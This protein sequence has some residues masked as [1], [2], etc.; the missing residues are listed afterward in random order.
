MADT[1]LDYFSKD[2][3]NYF[4]GGIKEIKEGNCKLLAKEIIKSLGIPSFEIVPEQPYPNGYQACVKQAALEEKNK[5]YP[6]YKE[7]V[8]IDGYKNIVLLFP[9]WMGTYPRLIAAFLKNHDLKNKNIL[10]IVSN[11]G[12]GLGH[13][14]KDLKDNT[15]ANILSGIEFKGH[16]VAKRSDEIVASIAKLMEGSAL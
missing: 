14:L 10:P 8:S 6:T 2:G 13:S 3:E 1:I 9:C 7:D 15:P 4:P 11:E 16:E 5:D 12:S